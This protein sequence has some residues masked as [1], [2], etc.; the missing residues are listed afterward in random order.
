MIAWITSL[1]SVNFVVELCKNCDKNYD[2]NCN[3]I[4]VMKLVAKII[5]VFYV[6]NCRHC[7]TYINCLQHCLYHLSTIILCTVITNVITGGV[8]VDLE[9]CNCYRL[10]L[11]YI[12]LH[13]EKC[14]FVDRKCRK[15][16]KSFKHEKRN[17][18]NLVMRTLIYWRPTQS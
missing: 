7:N 12:E 8:Y 15:W 18:W 16:E 1:L 11:F 6:Q 3:Y 4:V 17:C 13:Y 2:S 9:Y 5:L 14:M 10:F